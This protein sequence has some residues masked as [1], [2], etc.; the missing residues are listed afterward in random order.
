M[1]DVVTGGST[2]YLHVTTDMGRQRYIASFALGY[3]LL[4]QVGAPLLHFVVNPALSYFSDPVPLLVH[5]LGIAALGAMFLAR[6]SAGLAAQVL[7]WATWVA[8]WGAVLGNV[9]SGHANHVAVYLAIAPLVAGLLAYAS[10]VV[11]VG[12]L[13]VFGAAVLG[14]TGIVTPSTAM[15][16]ALLTMAATLFLGISAYTRHVDQAVIGGQARQLMARAAELEAIMGA[17]SE[18][19]IAL[20]AA[21]RIVDANAAAVGMTGD[22]PLPRGSHI[23]HVLPERLVEAIER[24]GESM[25][26]GP[27]HVELDGKPVLRVSVR[28]LTGSR[29]GHLV[30]LQDVTEERAAEEQRRLADLHSAEVEK[31]QELNRFKANLLNAASHELNTPL[32]PVRLQVELLR[33]PER[34]PLNDRQI[35]S[36]DILDRNIR[37]L[38]AL[39]GDILDVAKLDGSKMPLRC[40]PVA[41]DALVRDEVGQ[42]AQDA[43]ESG[44]ELKVE[45]SDRAWVWGDPARLGQVL[46]NLVGNAIKFTRQGQVRVELQVAAGWASVTVE[47]TGVGVPLGSEANLFEPFGQLHT[48]AHDA[49][50][51][52]MGLFV[53]KGI[54]EAHGGQLGF[55]RHEAG[56]RFWF[57]IPTDSM[58][59]QA[60]Q[61]VVAN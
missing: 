33:S 48:L 11:M 57:R 26:A 34:G 5:A 49:D 39:I 43:E 6:R 18:G 55:E 22:G 45:I 7:L 35:H 46:S 51:A 10:Y 9:E 58:D 2:R 24:L 12:G 16:A 32:T 1:A 20:D 47:D 25:D 44:L 40:V 17:A 15:N 42:F 21:G 23:S 30:T 61:Q 41:F 29:E 54:V 53:S 38:S 36:L 56:S 28:K 52:G 50:G 37:R 14:A 27:A 13:N 31:L 60:L 4:C 3:F 8:V 59:P 19:M